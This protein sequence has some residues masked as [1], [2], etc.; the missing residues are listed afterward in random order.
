M[1]HDLRSQL[2]L[3]VRAALF[4]LVAASCVFLS[5]TGGFAQSTFATLT[6]TV[7]DPS[8]APVPGVELV[9]THVATN[10]E[11]RGISNDFGVYNLPQ[12]REGE[13]VLKAEMPGFKQFVARN[14]IL[15][16]HDVRRIDI[17]LE[18]GEVADTVEVYAGTTLIETD[19]ARVTEVRSAKEINTLP[20]NRRSIWGTMI[21]TPMY[22]NVNGTQPGFAGSREYQWELSVDGASTA[23]GTNGWTVGNLVDTSESIQ[24]LHINTVNNS[25]ES[26]TLARI[27]VITKSGS[28]DFHGSVYDLYSTP[29]FRSRN[30]ITNVAA[31]G[32]KHE[33][34]FSLS[35]PVVI[36]GLYNGKNRTFWYL[37]ADNSYANSKQISLRPTVPLASWKRGDFSALGI[38]IRNPITGE[39][40]EN[41]IIP[42]NW[43]NPVAKKIQDRFYPDPNVSDPERFRTQNFEQDFTATA[44]RAPVYTIRLDH[45]VTENDSVYVTFRDYI[46]KSNSTWEGGLPAFGFRAQNRHQKALNLSYSRVFTP[47]FVNEFRIGHSFDNNTIVAPI[48]GNEIVEYLGLE[49]LAPNLP[50]VSGMHRVSFTGI[51]I[52]GLSQSRQSSPNIWGKT[53][54]FQDTI[55]WF[56]GKHALKFGGQLMYQRRDHYQQD[57]NLHGSS[58]F[59]AKF[60][61]V[62]GVANSGHAYADFLFGVPTQVQRAFPALRRQPETWPFS[63]FLQDDWK[64]TSRL[65]LNLGIRYEVQPPWS[66]ESGMISLFDVK[67]GKIVIADAGQNLISPLFPA[68]YADIV[69]AS[70]VGMDPRSLIRTDRNNWAPRLGLA[71]R[72]FDDKTVIRAGYGIYYDN[73]VRE[74]TIGGVPFVIAEPAYTNPDTPTVIWPRVFPTAGVAGPA[75]ISLPTAINPDLAVPYSQQWN[76]TLEHERW[77]TGFRVSYVGTGTRQMVFGRN[78]NAPLPDGELF[79]NKPRPFPQ[80]PNINYLENGATHTYHAL[81]IEVQR[82]VA[83][84]L[85]FQSGWT[86]ASDV[87]DYLDTAGIIENPFDRSRERG[88]QMNTPRHR[89]VNSII[90][91][92][93]FGRN[94]RWLN[95][96]PA[97]VNAIAGGWQLSAMGVM[98]TGDFLTPT[99][100]I[101]DPTGTAYTASGNRPLVT[102]RPDLV[103]D[104]SVSNPDRTGWFNVDA[105]QAPPIGRFGNSGRGLVTGPGVHLW[106]LGMF[107]YFDLLADGRA[108]ARIGLTATNG[109]NRPNWSNPN[110]DITNMTARGQITA[111]GGVTGGSL[112][113]TGGPRE[114]Q[115][116]L[117]VEW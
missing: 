94:R 64:V 26:G 53:T 22:T 101:P 104:P 18:L 97:V 20:A 31:A 59:S 21:V 84:G 52:Q 92:L 72:P 78:Y 102:I 90:Y 87:G 99:V 41:G 73:V 108:R 66:E 38:Q 55:S 4:L 56:V 71:Y 40:Y 98:Q 114:F 36:P 15:S 46:L 32:I 116:N 39:I 83:V 19:T 24:E 58:T 42:A 13:Y 81:N 109:F 28:N 65:T 74:Q 85:D 67:S 35:G 79:I 57:N 17:R 105:F 27:N 14:V 45:K 25:A 117:R 88:P 7:T 10:L 110:V 75:S 61:K 37:G 44:D 12:L 68:G 111:V 69:T 86:W 76:I 60:T 77:N 63:F 95:S 23:S 30:P 70:S 6:G 80:Y 100:R 91:D 48:G 82:N 34:G 113:D 54:N 5:T 103:G 47:N 1:A 2:V 9:A 115:L 29:K 93:P 16:T 3:P 33:P 51:G 89:F 49:G 11:W 112:G 107:K 8:G 50:D 62:P 96:A 43:I 106:H